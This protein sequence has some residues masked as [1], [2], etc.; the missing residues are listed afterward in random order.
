[1]RGRSGW[2]GLRAFAWDLRSG[3]GE[4]AEIRVRV[5]CDD[6]VIL[7]DAE[8]LW[9]ESVVAG[10]W[11]IEGGTAETEGLA[12][13]MRAA[14]AQILV[15]REGPALH[16]GPRRYDRCWIRD[17]AGMS[18][19]LLQ[20]GCRDAVRELLEWYAP[21]VRED[22]FVPCLVDSAGPDWLPE[23]DSQGQFV[24]IIAEYLRYGGDRP[25]VERLWPV[26]LRT[27][28]YLVQL[29]ESRMTPEF[30]AGNPPHRYGLLPES[31][32]HEGTSPI[33]CIP[34]WDD[35]W[36]LRGIRDAVWLAVE[37]G[38]SERL[39]SLR[40]LAGQLHGDLGGIAFGLDP[41]SRA[42]L[43]AG[44]RG[45]GGLRSLRH[46]EWIDLVGGTARSD[47]GVAGPLP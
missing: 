36:A 31:A 46:R 29:R 22:G 35:F 9:R 27:M 33:R 13:A 47:A 12:L 15:N 5:N 37:L 1:M 10:A 19:A 14:N 41:G 3:P 30:R 44:L 21:Y 32:S 2:T 4:T 28:D 20:A 34:D 24:H 45:M 18:R 16:P 11:R 39:A 38:D 43:R 7:E 8:A 23:Y 17:A 42:R 6:G 25:V 26:A 40:A